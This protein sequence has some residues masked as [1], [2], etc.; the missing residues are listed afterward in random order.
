LVQSIFQV[1]SNGKHRLIRI[2]CI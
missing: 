2:F 1:F